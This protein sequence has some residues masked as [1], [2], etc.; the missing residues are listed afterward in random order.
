M[1]IGR[2]ARMA[3]VLVDKNGDKIAAGVNRATD[4]VDKKTNGKHREKL[5]KIDDMA[6][7]LDKSPDRKGGRESTEDPPPAP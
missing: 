4:L 5:T 6:S 7:K 1:N 3:K 2:L